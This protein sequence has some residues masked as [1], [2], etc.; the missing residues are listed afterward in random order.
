MSIPC[1]HSDATTSVALSIPLDAML[2][3]KW[4]T[5]G[6]L[7]RVRCGKSLLP[8]Y[9][10][11]CLNSPAGRD[12]CW[13][14]KSD[15]VSQSNINAKKLAAFQFDLPTVEEQ[16]EIIRRVEILFTFADRLESRYQA[17]RAKCDQLTPALL[18]KAFQGELVPQDPN[19]E[20]ASVLL[21]RIKSLRSSAEPNQAKAQRRARRAG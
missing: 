6:Y 3:P 7:I 19:D 2:L 16:K 13:Q 15:G 18:E 12:Y 4:D 14:V 20:P 9:L 21:E 10:N 8:D 5:P 1:L 11:Y 17:A